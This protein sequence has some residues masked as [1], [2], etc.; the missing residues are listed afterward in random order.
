MLGLDGHGFDEEPLPG[1]QARPAKKILKE[2]AVVSTIPTKRPS[3]GKRSE[4]S[5]SPST[6]GSSRSTGRDQSS[7]YNTPL[8]SAVATP[9]ESTTKVESSIRRR[10]RPSKTL[11][12]TQLASSRKRKRLDLNE[13]EADAALAQTL[14][15]EEYGE[16]GS[17]PAA[18]AL[19]RRLVIEDSDEDGSMLS[20]LSEAESSDQ[21]PSKKR[22]K[23][24]TIL[25]ARRA[26]NVA[27][28]SL[29]STAKTTIEDSEEGS[30]SEF[31]LPDSEDA[32]LVDED[33]PSTASASPAP[34]APASITTA[35]SAR[36]RRRGRP[37]AAD[38]GRRQR[39]NERR[40]AG[41]ND[42]VSLPGEACVG[43]LTCHRR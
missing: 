11:G 26:R 38:A 4:P 7:G 3:L 2:V 5:R 36:R 13:L 18:E 24:K 22:T 15:A 12:L 35:S 29:T 19:N 6:I 28:K 41:L 31:S 14:Q 16:I 10:G 39:W 25:P 27:R 40:I 21:G 9:A 33:V 23:A 42:R 17:E 37:S 1:K 20:E 43:L 34:E 32:D 30:E 8:T